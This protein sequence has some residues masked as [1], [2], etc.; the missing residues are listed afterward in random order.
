MRSKVP[1]L[2]CL[3]FYCCDALIHS[4][5]I[6]HSQSGV[7]AVGDHIFIINS[8]TSNKARISKRSVLEPTKI[9]LND[10]CEYCT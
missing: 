10:S 6:L 9:F 4:L 8:H 2:F 3:Q 1:K 7:Y 5:Y